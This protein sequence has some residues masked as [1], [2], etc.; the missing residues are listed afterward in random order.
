ML[1]IGQINQ[2][3]KAQILA[4]KPCFNGKFKI[5]TTNVV[6]KFVR[7]SSVEEK[8]QKLYQNFLNS[9]SKVEPSTIEAI[10]KKLKNYPRK[11]VLSVM[12][13]LSSFSNINAFNEIYKDLALQEIPKFHSFIDNKPVAKYVEINKNKRLIK[14]FDKNK[15]LTL[16][17]VFHYLY[18]SLSA[19]FSKYPF[20]GPSEGLILDKPTLNYLKTLNKQQLKKIKDYKFFIIKDLENSYNIFNQHNDFETLVRKN[21]NEIEVLRKKY[22]TKEIS[23]LIDINL[24]GE[25]LKGS[26]ELGITPIIISRNQPK[27]ITPETISQ[28]LSPIIPNKNTF[29]KELERCLNDISIF[30]FRKEIALD[31]LANN[32]HIYTFKSMAKKL[33]EL[34]K[35]IEERVKSNGRDINKIFYNVPST[36]KSFSFI[37]YMYQQINNIPASQILYCN[38]NKNFKYLRDLYDEIGRYLPEGST[39]VTL[40]DAIISG[41]SL[42]VYPYCYIPDRTVGDYDM[43][44]ASLYSTPKANN[45]LIK[46]KYGHKNNDS[47]ICVD[48]DPGNYNKI[49]K[50]L[51]SSTTIKERPIIMFPYMA[52]D[53]NSNDIRSL[54]KIFYPKDG[55]FVKPTW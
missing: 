39:L 9:L 40:D 8:S 24:N 11:E 45:N 17:E 48:Y 36:S 5:Q 3:Q 47:I 33:Q 52:P 34:K 26:K 21:L 49:K 28:N 18:T 6:D 30:D 14:P 44:F 27:E 19:K 23:E 46:H 29:N 51:L 43:I 35:L 7:T 1:N 31:M 32:N 42:F 13:A 20:F 12:H 37:S 2:T 53:N 10:V 50:I 16:N 55:S 38:T 4:S 15:P 54:L 25:S 22:P 41:D